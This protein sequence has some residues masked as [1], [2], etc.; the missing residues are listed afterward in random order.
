MRMEGG[1]IYHVA[2]HNGVLVSGSHNTS[3]GSQDESNDNPSFSGESSCG[4]C[5]RE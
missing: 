2:W 3:S 5:Y 4:L 1:G